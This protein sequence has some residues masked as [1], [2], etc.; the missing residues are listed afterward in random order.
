MREERV[1]ERWWW[2]EGEVGNK[3]N[4]EQIVYTV[5]A[6]VNSVGNMFGLNTCMHL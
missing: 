5:T 3:A 4:S 6:G 1:V 2:E